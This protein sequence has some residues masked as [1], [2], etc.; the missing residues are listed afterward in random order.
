[1]HGGSELEER[2]QIL[3]TFYTV[4]SIAVGPDPIILEVIDL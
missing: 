1:M 3:D 4:C 2:V